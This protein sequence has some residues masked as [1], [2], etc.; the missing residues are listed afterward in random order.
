MLAKVIFF[1]GAAIVSLS[2]VASIFSD[3][4]KGILKHSILG[5]IGLTMMVTILAAALLAV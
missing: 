3:G 5:A 4:D 1:G 2:V